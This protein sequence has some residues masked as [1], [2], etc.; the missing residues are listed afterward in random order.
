MSTAAPRL[1]SRLASRMGVTAWIACAG[2]T[3]FVVGSGR[4]GGLLGMGLTLAVTAGLA[5]HLG[6][7]ARTRAAHLQRQRGQI[8]AL[9]DAARAMTSASSLA[10][11]L[12]VLAN[13][14]RRLARSDLAAIVFAPEGNFDAPLVQVSA[15]S[16]RTAL[17]ALERLSGPEGGELH[18]ELEP[19][20]RMQRLA[21]SEHAPG[22]ALGCALSAFAPTWWAAAIRTRDHADAGLILVAESPK[23]ALSDE[24]RRSLEQ[25]VQMALAAAEIRRSQLSL[26]A[27]VRERTQRL[28]RANQQLAREAATRRRAES[29]AR[30]SE[31][32]FRLLLD[33]TGEGI[34]G[35]DRDGRCIFANQ[36]CLRMLGYDSLDELLGQPIHDLVHP[37]SPSEGQPFAGTCRIQLAHERGEELHL[38]DEILWRRDGSCFPAEYTSQPIRRD[39][40]VMGS[41]VSFLDISERTQ[42]REQLERHAG[43]LARSNEELEQFAYVASHDLQEPLRMVGSFAQLLAKRYQGR[44][45]DEAD[46]FIGYLVDGAKRMQQL[47]N[48]LLEYSRVGT[49]GGAL[50][51]VNADACLDAALDNLQLAIEESDA[52]ISREPLPVVHA[53]ESQIVQLFQNLIGNAIKFRGDEAPRIHVRAKKQDCDWRFEIRDN[54]IGIDPAFQDR[55]FQIF[56]RLH[57]KSEYPGTGIGLA[58]CKRIV[59]RHGGCIWLDSQPGRGT[60]FYF[61][62]PAEHYA[63]ASAVE[64]SA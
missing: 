15:V 42:A 7:T 50:T 19:S 53:E 54:G 23:H 28:E 39:G 4:V 61:T 20:G 49:H 46:E 59:A 51:A 21:L 43:E 64:A 9:H 38:D 56:Q 55:I 29:A 35:V 22:P 44:L 25:L 17:E 1:S 52:V 41:V 33:S 18:A 60:T 2:L 8:A 13:L 16:E 45:D 5:T 24:D 3:A 12:Q 26:E 57:G 63:S 32:R 58:L 47:I 30:E 11:V 37:H 31:E 34:Y 62:L 36:A 6:R 48:D 10:E 14:A 40:E 27:R